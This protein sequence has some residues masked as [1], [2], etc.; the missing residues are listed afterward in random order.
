MR[1]LLL[2]LKEKAG[3]VRN[4]MNSRLMS[5]AAEMAVKKEEGSNAIVIEI[6][7]IVV[8]VVLCIFFKDQIIDF[9]KELF[10]E[11]ETQVKSIF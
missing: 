8:A 7:L 2:S 11:V 5:A 6:I 3:N 10:A 1:N 9:T 4:R